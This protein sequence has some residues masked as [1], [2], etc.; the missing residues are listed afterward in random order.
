[1]ALGLAMKSDSH[2]EAHQAL[3][4]CVESLRLASVSEPVSKALAVARGLLRR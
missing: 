4:V 2:V 1:M 3:N